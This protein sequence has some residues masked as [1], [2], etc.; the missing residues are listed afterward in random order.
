MV[1]S[2]FVSKLITW[3]GN[4]HPPYYSVQPNCGGKLFHSQLDRELVKSSDKL[5]LAQAF[6]NPLPVALLRLSRLY[7]D[8]GW[9]SFCRT[10]SAVATAMTSVARKPPRLHESLVREPNQV[11]SA[12][13]PDLSRSST[14]GHWT[15]AV[16]WFKTRPLSR[17][18]TDT[19]MDCSRCACATSPPLGQQR[20]S[21]TTSRK[22]LCKFLS[23]PANDSVRV[24]VNGRK[25]TLA[26]TPPLAR[27]QLGAST[28]D[29]YSKW[30]VIRWCCHRMQWLCDWGLF[31]ASRSGRWTA[32]Y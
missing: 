14:T 15:T 24:P 26:S 18:G 1:D 2:T 31:V 17:P 29:R 30:L 20:R 6:H 25:T 8:L 28:F 27:F 11:T 23:R 5:V 21:R 4:S 12:Q 19:L 13:L 32:L 3:Q 9:Y 16:E 10:Y 22:R 7:S